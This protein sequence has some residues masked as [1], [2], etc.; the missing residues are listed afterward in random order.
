MAGSERR[1]RGFSLVEA[2]LVIVF[3]AVSFLGL[4][5]LFGNV[6]QQ[7]LKADLT[8]LATK[9]ARE[10]MEEVVQRKADS[11]YSAVVSQS[12]ASVQ[13]GA[14]TFTRTVTVQYLDPSTFVTTGA[15]TGYKRVEVS[16]SW[17]AGSGQSV[18]LTTLVTNMVPSSV[19]GTGYAECS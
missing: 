12:A 15:D 3:L 6:T 4:A 18:T 10:K 11:G 1:Q 7:A 17:G 14:W 19:V 16:V 2:V 8:V 13:S 9:L 5:Y